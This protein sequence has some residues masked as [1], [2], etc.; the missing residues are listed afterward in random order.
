MLGQRRRR[1]PNIKLAWA[2]PLVLFTGRSE[3]AIQQAT[4]H[5]R[6]PASSV[7]VRMRR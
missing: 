7:R 1:W 6:I 4:F 5:L 3:E 2:Q